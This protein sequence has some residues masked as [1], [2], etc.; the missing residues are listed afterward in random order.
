MTDIKDK[1]IPANVSD[2]VRQLI[3]LQGDATDRDFCRKYNF[4][5]NETNWS[6]I[7]RGVYKGNPETA[8]GACAAMLRSIRERRAVTSK[9]RAGTKFIDFTPA[10]TVKGRI[11]LLMEE[12]GYNQ[13]RLVMYLADSG[14]GKSALA[15]EIVALHG[16]CI[17]E[18]RES[19]RGSYFNALLDVCSALGVT[20]TD[21]ER[22]P[23]RAEKALVAHL[24][25]RRIILAID[26]AEYFGPNSLNLLKFLLNQTKVIVLVLA[27]PELW[28]RVQTKSYVEARQIMRRTDHVER[29]DRIHPDE[30]ERFLVESGVKLNGSAAEAGK[31]MAVHANKFGGFDLLKRVAVRLADEEEHTDDEVETTALGVLAMLGFKAG[32]VK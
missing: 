31:K 17:V 30:A 14:R 11:N 16:G 19:W 22:S 28:D 12:E 9:V 20:G 26:E 15:R 6:K 8:E 18:A 21:I 5:L 13:N 32:G 7:R 27:I 1:T 2:T 29:L 4:A 23:R 25:D 10:R 3:E 24:G